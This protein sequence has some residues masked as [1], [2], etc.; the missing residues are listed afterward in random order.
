V[1]KNKFLP[2]T[3]KAGCIRQLSHADRAKPML[4]AVGKTNKLGTQDL[5]KL[6]KTE[7]F[8]LYRCF[9]FFGGR[10]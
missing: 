6:N 8:E 4:S 9:W 7:P 5:K 1:G 3:E 2:K 10:I